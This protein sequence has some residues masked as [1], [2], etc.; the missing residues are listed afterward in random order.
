[1]QKLLEIRSYTLK[2]GSAQEFHALIKDYSLPLMQK[3]HIDVVSFGIC[4]EC[5][6]ACYLIRAFNDVAD[7]NASQDAFYASDDWR[8]GPREAIISL[9][10]SS[11]AARFFLSEN[12][13]DGMR[14]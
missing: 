2:P 11:T 4:A 13:I 6:D 10:H 5:D 3:W 8:K 7:L 14:L 1:M 12:L 9:I